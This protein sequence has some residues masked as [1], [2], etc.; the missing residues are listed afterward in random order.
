VEDVR[1]H[2]GVAA[3]R[4]RIEEATA[5]GLTPLCRF[6]RPQNRLGVRDDMRLIA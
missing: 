6:G 2:V 1:E 3:L 4:N 5:N